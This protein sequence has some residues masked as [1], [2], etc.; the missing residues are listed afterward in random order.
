M[1]DF[2]GERMVPGRAPLMLEMAHRA[3]YR[4]ALPQC[5][6][7]TVLDL[8]CGAGYGSELLA[9]AAAA[10]LGIDI[11]A[12]AVAHARNQ[13][14]AANLSFQTATIDGIAA[15]G[16][17]YDVVVSFE[18]IEHTDDPTG[19]LGSIAAVLSPG[20]HLLIST[21]N[22]RDEQ[23]Q[24]HS[25]GWEA[26]GFKAL[27]DERFMVLELLGQG[28]SH[29]VMLHRQQERNALAS[30]EQRAAELKQGNP[31][32]K[33][34]PRTL[35]RFAYQRMVEYRLAPQPQWTESDFPIGAVTA[36]SEVLI[37]C[38]TRR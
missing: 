26:T 25:H 2:T 20:G 6:G 33:L 8:G 24:Y 23:N 38:C 10:A 7:K 1:M 28:A 11:S 16:Q 35:R 21:P 18:V 19:F 12:E 13:Y 9:Q 32:I 3:R 27:L 5:A 4:W 22:G 29:R 31:L 15:T 36:D 37:A 14:R 30:S 17:K 34:I